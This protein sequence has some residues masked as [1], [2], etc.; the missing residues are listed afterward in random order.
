MYSIWR[1]TCLLLLLLAAPAVARADRYVLV[2]GV[3]TEALKNRKN[4]TYRVEASNVAQAFRA[5][6]R[7][8]AGR[9]HVRQILGARATRTNILNGLRW[10]SRMRRRDTAFVYFC[11]HGVGSTQGFT[12]C[13]VGYDGSRWRQTGVT[14]EEIREAVARLRGP[15][16][17]CV[18]AC[19]S[20]WLLKQ[21]GGWGNCLA[22]TSCRPTETSWL[23]VMG[24]AVL[25]A[26]RGRADANRDGVVTVR[27]FRNYVLRRMR[28]LK[29][30]QHPVTKDNPAIH[31]VAL[32]R[33]PKKK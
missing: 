19:N 14:G 30:E 5:H 25:E 3:D 28:R 18:T 26:L 10:L 31:R 8:L 15:C 29:K 27:E 9:T 24:Q 21:R 17:L 4:D 12:V 16:V 6:T 22:I 2:I 1:T 7:R 32:T 23:G 20:G 33:P 13:P 11:M